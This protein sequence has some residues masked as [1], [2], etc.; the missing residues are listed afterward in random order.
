MLAPFEFTGAKFKFEYFKNSKCEENNFSFKKILKGEKANDFYKYLR[1]FVSKY[2]QQVKNSEGDVIQDILKINYA[3]ITNTKDGTPRFE[4]VG[5]KNTSFVNPKTVL[6]V[7]EENISQ[8]YNKALKNEK[9]VSAI[10]IFI[11]LNYLTRN[12]DKVA[13]GVEANLE[14]KEVF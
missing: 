8:I 9:E 7:I 4:D 10:T 1:S 14:R 12:L 13:L 5:V 6:R 2:Y 3:L 11:E